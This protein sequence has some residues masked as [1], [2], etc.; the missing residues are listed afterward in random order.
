VP[1]DGLDL[2][3][4]LRVVLGSGARLADASLGRALLVLVRGRTRGDLRHVA[5]IGRRAAQ[6]RRERER[7]HRDHEHFR[8]E[9]RETAERGAADPVGPRDRKV[10]R[11]GRR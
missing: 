5:G 4:G 11:G 7:T 6:R 3:V 1:G 2:L 10:G 9:Q 8:E